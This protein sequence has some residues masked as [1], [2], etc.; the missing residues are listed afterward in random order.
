MIWLVAL[1]SKWTIDLL[2]IKQL[3]SLG[4]SLT[5]KY[6]IAYVSPNQLFYP[7]LLFAKELI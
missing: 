4:S 6:D 2:S 1:T 7:P 5:E 3:P